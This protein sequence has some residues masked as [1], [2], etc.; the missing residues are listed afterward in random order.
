MPRHTALNATQQQPAKHALQNRNAQK[1]FT[2]KQSSEANTRNW[3]TTT[4]NES[5]KTSSFT[6]NGNKLWNTPMAP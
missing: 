4:K 2:E 1:P 3:W 6:G 5:T